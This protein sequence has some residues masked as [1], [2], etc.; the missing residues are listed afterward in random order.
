MNPLAKIYERYQSPA[1]WGD[2]GTIHS[3]IDVYEELMAPFRFKPGVQVL[4]IGIMNGACIR[5][6]EEYFPQGIIYGVDLCDRPLDMVDL[7]PMIAEGT[8]RIVL[9]DAANAEQVQQNFG[10]ML[11]DVIIEDANH[12]LDQQVA[13][14]RNFQDKLMPNGLYVIEDVAELEKDQAVYEN[15][16][17]SR[18]IRILDRRFI[19]KR[20]DDVLVVIGGKL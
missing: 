2:K 19:K 6:W 14:Y 4:E 5:M 9:M 17:P 13:I 12:T 3:Y 10:G 11:F 15:L 8:H 18:S 20:F 7:R 16:D 1:S